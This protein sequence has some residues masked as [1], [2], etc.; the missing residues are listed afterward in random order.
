MISK[1]FQVFIFDRDIWGV[2]NTFEEARESGL[3]LMMDCAEADE[4]KEDAV[5]A[6]ECG[7]YIEVSVSAEDEHFEGAAKIVLSNAEWHPNTGIK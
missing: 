3:K 4:T 2:G 7:Y 5:K 6:M 1:T